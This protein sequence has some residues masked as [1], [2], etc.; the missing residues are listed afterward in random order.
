VFGQIRDAFI[1]EDRLVVAM[2]GGIY[3]IYSMLW[4]MDNCTTVKT[5]LGDYC[6]LGQGRGGVV[7]A[8]EFGVPLTTNVTG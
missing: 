3:R 4:I 5:S 2:E 8:T 7:G 1:N 6:D